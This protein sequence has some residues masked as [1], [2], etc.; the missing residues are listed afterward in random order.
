MLAYA[1]IFIRHMPLHAIRYAILPL[2]A[3]IATDFFDI[4]RRL[5]SFRLYCQLAD[6]VTIRHAAIAAAYALTLRYQLRLYATLLLL[7]LPSHT[8]LLRIHAA[9]PH[10]LRFS[11]RLR[12]MPR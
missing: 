4:L 8:L 3:A 6:Y 1:D 10:R 2:L 5:S 7:P 9:M 11:P 12:Q